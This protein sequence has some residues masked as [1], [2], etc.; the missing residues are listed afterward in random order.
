MKPTDPTVR[1]LV[2][3]INDGNRQGFVDLLADGATM[4]DDGSERELEAWI[5]REI[6]TPHGRMEVV[7]QTDDGR[8]LI[9]DFTNDTWG[10]MRT[11]W[12]FAVKDGRISR[13]ETG[14]A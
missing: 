8:A 1:A 13:F 7:S 11:E 3:A 14:Q 9:A 2:Q 12:R 6:F 5:D 10:Q 4:S